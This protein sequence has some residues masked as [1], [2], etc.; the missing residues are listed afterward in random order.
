MIKYFRTTVRFRLGEALLYTRPICLETSKCS[1][2]I[3]LIPQFVRQ[4][5]LISKCIYGVCAAQFVTLSFSLK[6]KKKVINF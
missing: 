6:I 4:K 3:Y 1:L 2:Q 5:L